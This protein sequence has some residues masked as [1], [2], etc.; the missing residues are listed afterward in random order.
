MEYTNEVKKEKKQIKAQ[1]KQLHHKLQ[2]SRKHFM[3]HVST[4]YSDLSRT[5]Q[6]HWFGAIN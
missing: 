2:Q 5:Q 4:E 3:F 6:E 1:I